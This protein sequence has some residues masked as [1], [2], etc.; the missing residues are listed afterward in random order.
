MFPDTLL[1]KLPSKNKSN[2]VTC[3]CV[4][5]PNAVMLPSKSTYNYYLA[6]YFFDLKLKL[7]TYT[8]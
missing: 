5:I 6:V 2:K 1:E 8:S 4:I 7:N 3:V